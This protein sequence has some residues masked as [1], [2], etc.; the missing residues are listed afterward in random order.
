M[1]E[2]VRTGAIIVAL[3]LGLVFSLVAAVGIVRLP[4]VYSRAH[5]V[6]KV[7]TLGTG[8]ALVAVAIAAGTG[9]TAV[10]AILLV[11]F[12]FLTNPTAAHA[13]TRA[14]SEEGVEPWT[15]EDART[16]ADPER[17]EG[18]ERR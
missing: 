7:D 18:G 15:R 3:G 8:F 12:V 1:I 6:S 4:D 2:T 5:A 14:A 17:T 16:D 13:I 11:A 10:K 9:L